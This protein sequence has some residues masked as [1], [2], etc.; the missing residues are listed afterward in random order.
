M[1]TY[2]IW[3]AIVEF[4]LKIPSKYWLLIVVVC[5]LIGLYDKKLRN[6]LFFLIFVPA[7]LYIFCFGFE[8]I[9]RIPYVWW[10]G[11]VLGLTLDVCVVREIYRTIRDW[12]EK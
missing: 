4:G 3:E 8:F 6:A 10:F 9:T 2:P 12:I 7:M 11:Y 1:F 5:F